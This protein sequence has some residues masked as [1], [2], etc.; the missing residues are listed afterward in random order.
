MSRQKVGVKKTSFGKTL[1]SSQ[2]SVAMEIRGVVP[3]DDEFM[4]DSDPNVNSPTVVILATPE[5]EEEGACPPVTT[6]VSHVQHDHTYSYQAT[7]TSPFPADSELHG[8]LSQELFSAEHTE[9]ASTANME[10]R[11]ER[12]EIVQHSSADANTGDTADTDPNTGDTT[13]INADAVDTTDVGADS[14]DTTDI[15][16]SGADGEMMEIS[17]DGLAEAEELGENDPSHAPLENAESG[18]LSPNKQPQSLSA[19]SASPE[20]TP[21]APPPVHALSPPPNSDHTYNSEASAES[22]TSKAMPPNTSDHTPYDGG[23]GDAALE[24]VFELLDQLEIMFANSTSKS[25][26]QVVR[27]TQRLVGFASTVSSSLKPA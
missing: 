19:E 13:D 7:P 17:H 8:M 27:L 6:A 14:A 2:G 15:T 3:D 10:S 12:T 18:S 11:I 22:A 4:L 20:A 25:N 16:A 23:D 1:L 21:P 26:D 24:E 5:S 9:F